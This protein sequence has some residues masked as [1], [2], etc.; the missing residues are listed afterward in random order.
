MATRLAHNFSFANK[1]LSNKKQQI[2]APTSI[3]RSGSSGNELS[4]IQ[5]LSSSNYTV[6]EATLADGPCRFC[7]AAH[8]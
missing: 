8:I 3:L 1:P 6:L 5:R 7:G 2:V 4:R